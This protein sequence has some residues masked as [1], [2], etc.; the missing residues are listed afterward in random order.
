MFYGGG[1]DLIHAMVNVGN[2]F[3]WFHSLAVFLGGFFSLIFLSKTLNHIAARTTWGIALFLIVV[4]GGSIIYPNVVPKM[5]GSGEF[6][7]M[8]KMLN[9][10]GS[11]GYLM[12]AIY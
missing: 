1:F 6:S 2:N 11:F 5:T 12:A 9:I 3:V 4:I 8:A 7:I 10:C